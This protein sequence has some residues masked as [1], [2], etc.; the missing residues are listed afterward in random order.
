[1]S[2]ATDKVKELEAQLEE[3]QKSQLFCTYYSPGTFFLEQSRFE[4]ETRS[5]AACATRAKA[6]VKERH[7]AKPFAFRFTD[8]NGKSLSG[9]HYLTGKVIRLDEVP[10]DKEHSIMRSNMFDPDRCVVVEN[11]NSYKHVSH[12]SEGDVIVDWEGNVVRRGDEPEL[13]AYRAEV[14][15]QYDEEYGS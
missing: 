5:V 1:M 2:S 15:K 7:G 9:L 8:G 6:D 11:T 13:V 4:I 12:F 14:K 3:A 10:D